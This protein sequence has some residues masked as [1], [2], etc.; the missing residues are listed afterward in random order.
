MLFMLKK[1]SYIH[2]KG[3]RFYDIWDKVKDLL[4]KDQEL[5]GVAHDNK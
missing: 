2:Q 4:G 5:V 3:K 1:S